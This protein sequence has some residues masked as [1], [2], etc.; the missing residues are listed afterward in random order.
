MPFHAEKRFAEHKNHLAAHLFDLMNGFALV[1]KIIEK[2]AAR[3]AFLI[4]QRKDE[5][6][7]I[8]ILKAQDQRMTAVFTENGFTARIVGEAVRC[9]KF[10]H[11][12]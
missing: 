12:I 8:V 2:R 7:R 4:F 9:G 1:L 11:E 6:K 3:H 5:G 10:E